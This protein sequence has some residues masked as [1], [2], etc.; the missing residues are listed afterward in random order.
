MSAFV[1][2]PFPFLVAESMMEVSRAGSVRE[3][4]GA[5]SHEPI[6]MW[7]V[8]KICKRLTTPMVVMSEDTWKFSF[9]KFLEV[10]SRYIYSLILLRL[11]GC[12]S[13]I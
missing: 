3:S 5:V 10:R 13:F 8:C 6:Y 1:V 12:G 7:S 2:L 9:G 4:A 11:S